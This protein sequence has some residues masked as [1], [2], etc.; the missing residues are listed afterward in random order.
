MDSTST[1]TVV[2]AIAQIKFKLLG[3][4]GGGGGRGGWVSRVFHL[5]KSIDFFLSSGYFNGSQFFQDPRSN[6]KNAAGG[7]YIIMG[8][9]WLIGVPV[10][11]VAIVMVRTTQV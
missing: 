6:K 2:D 10:L 3:W 4:W 1:F 5:H 7:M 8:F 11:A 9:L